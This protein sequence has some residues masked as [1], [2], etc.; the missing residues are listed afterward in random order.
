MPE[1]TRWPLIA[2]GMPVSGVLGP[3]IA[4]GTHASGALNAVS[5]TDSRRGDAFGGGW[6]TYNPYVLH[7]S[8]QTAM[9]SQ[10]AAVAIAV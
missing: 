4:T 10:P 6:Y 2:A 8:C 7:K 3:V 5:A 9:A 1:G